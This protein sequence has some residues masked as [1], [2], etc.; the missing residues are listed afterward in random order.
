MRLDI[1]EDGF[2]LTW[3]VISEQDNT[4]TVE[5]GLIGPDCAM[6]SRPSSTMILF[7]DGNRFF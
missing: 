5:L 4:L 2:M 7:L 6:A 3:K 1:S